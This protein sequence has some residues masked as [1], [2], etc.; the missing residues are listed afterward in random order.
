M[1]YNSHKMLGIGCLPSLSICVGRFQVC[2]VYA[3]LTVEV[4]SGMHPL[5]SR[6][7]DTV[8][9]KGVSAAPK[10]SEMRPQSVILR[11]NVTKLHSN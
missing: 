4:I 9:L 7:Q 6:L 11:P 8:P 3:S 2:H 10:R 5:E 1:A